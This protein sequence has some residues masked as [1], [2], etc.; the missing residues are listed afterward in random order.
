MNARRK[1]L[2]A[3]A[4]AGLVSGAPAFA[5][6]A[7]SIRPITPD[8]RLE[9]DFMAAFQ[10]E[11]MRPAFRARFLESQVALALAAGENAG[12]LHVTNASGAQ[13]GAVFTSPAR[14]ESVLGAQA[15]HIELTGREALTRLRGGNVAINYRLIPMLTLEAADVENFLRIPG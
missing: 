7:F 12:P 13:M 5:Q 14:L 3:L 1:V 15:P 9:S 8:N 6:S 2:F 11:A 4:G 10:S